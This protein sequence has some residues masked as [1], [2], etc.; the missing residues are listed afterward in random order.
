MGKLSIIKEFFGFLW[1]HKEWWLLPVAVAI[2]LL[3]VF[4]V[5]SGSFSVAPFIYAIF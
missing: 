2:L 5:T 1:E 3:A 4:I